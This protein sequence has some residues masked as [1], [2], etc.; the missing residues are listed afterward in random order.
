MQA[1]K[2]RHLT[3][4][5][6]A[7]PA[8]ATTHDF[9][10]ASQALAKPPELT[11]RDH[12]IMLLHIA[13]SIEHALM[14]QYLFAAYS[15]G[16]DQVPEAHRPMVE[17]WRNSILAVAKEE[18]GHLLTVQNVT[19]C[20]AARSVSIARTTRGTTR[21]IPRRS[22]SRRSAWGAWRSMSLP[23]CRRSGNTT[24]TTRRKSSGLSLIHI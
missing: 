2:L 3:E 24:T 23:R 22:P 17:G 15:L 16:G 4:L 18:M 20:S 11:W 19:P 8:D 21:S 14:V 10:T 1:R 7:V 13:A 6:S 5:A 12:A 9:A